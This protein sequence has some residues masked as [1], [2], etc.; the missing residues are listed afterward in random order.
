M[1]PMT[2]AYRTTSVD[3]EQS[4]NPRSVYERDSA[5]TYGYIS[6]SDGVL[7]GTAD[8][9]YETA[10]MS[11]SVTTFTSIEIPLVISRPSI[12][13]PQDSNNNTELDTV[14]DQSTNG[15]LMTEDLDL[16]SYEC[17]LDRQFTFSIANNA[18]DGGLPEV[19]EDVLA[20]FDP[21][22][23]NT[24]AQLNAL[25]TDGALVLTTPVSYTHLT[26]PTTPYV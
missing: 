12:V 17:L 8:S 3:F 16:R 5:I 9:S 11:V 4:G 18:V 15:A 13:N 22:V 19:V 21:G 14:V 7:T 26:L 6:D 1:K 25:F 10:D 24:Q 23:V 2:K 20:E